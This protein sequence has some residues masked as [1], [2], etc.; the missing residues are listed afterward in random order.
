MIAYKYLHQSRTSVLEEGLIR[1]TQSAALNDPFET[2]PDMRKLEQ[3]FRGHMIRA[4]EQAEL[5]DIEYAIARSQVRTRV[6][7]H[8]EEFLR[9]NSNTDYAILS[10][11]K[12]PNSL[13]MW[14]HYCD[15]YRGF[16]VGFDSTHPFFHTREFKRFST[17][18]E[19]HYS[20]ERPI[21][22][23]P[24]EWDGSQE[25]IERELSK[26]DLAEL[27]FYTKSEDW[28]YEQELRM[29]A[30]P[31]IADRHVRTTEGQDIY[32]YQFPLECLKQVIFGIRMPR[33]Q[34]QSIQQLVRE[35]YQGVQ[36]FE[37]ALSQEKF[38]LDIVP[39]N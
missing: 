20:N 30:N 37:A 3:S 38:D 24:E 39:F 28:K 11:S 5:S 1:F 2:T 18:E 35:K 17:L 31:Q 12:V 14:A 10:L 13:L 9:R 23:A 36:F 29:V 25:Q 16:V 33:D 4:I 26:Y 27:L 32:L 8:L 7:K 22:P 19:V 34:R 21:M 6:N 15:S